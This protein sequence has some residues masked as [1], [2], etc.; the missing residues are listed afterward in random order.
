MQQGYSKHSAISSE[1][2]CLF[3]GGLNPQVTKKAVRAHFSKY[4]KITDLFLKIDYIKNCNKGYAFVYFSNDTS[5]QK[6]L[7]EA[8]II[9]GR[10]VE[11]KKSQGRAYN[12]QDKSCAIRCKIYVG[13]IESNVSNQN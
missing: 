9:C 11:C 3:V 10:Q 5:L 7:Q 13:N 8:Q 2:N 12:N 6:I 4:G 1:N